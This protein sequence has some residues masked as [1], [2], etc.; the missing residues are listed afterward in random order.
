MQIPGP[1][2]RPTDAEY[3]MWSLGKFEDHFG[4]LSASSEICLSVE[5]VESFSRFHIHALIY[6]ICFSLSDF[7]L[8]DRL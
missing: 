7:T 2:P 4:V 5:S 3:I 6:I 1:Y 8:Y